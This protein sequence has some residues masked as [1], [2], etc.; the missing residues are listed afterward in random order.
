MN[1]PSDQE[2]LIGSWSEDKLRLL[3]EYL[4]RYTLIMQ[5]QDWCRNGYHYIDAFAGTGRPRARDE[6]RFIDGSPRIALSIKRPFH[7]YRFIEIEPWRIQRL[8]DLRAEFPSRDIRIFEEDCNEVLVKQIVP[9]IRYEHFNRGFVFLDPF[10]MNAEWPTVEQIAETRALEVF[11]NF[12]VMALNRTALPNDPNTLSEAQIGRMNRF[13]G[14]T[15]WRDLIYVERRDLWGNIVEMK[16]EPTSGR[17]LGSLFRE[18]LRQVFPF[19]TAPLVMKNSIGAP[20][21]CLIFAGHNKTGARITQYIF[22][23]YDRLGR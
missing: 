22:Q 23:R 2:D 21:Y 4:E 1:N 19:V 15:E 11:I 9:E 12:P 6:E 8:Q 13:W 5:G 16:I 18:R 7:S 3:R 10:T 20:L 14:S 17:R